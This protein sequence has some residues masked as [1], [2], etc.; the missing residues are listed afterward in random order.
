[1]ILAVLWLPLDHQMSAG[2]AHRQSLLTRLL[3]LLVDP[4]HRMIQEPS[5]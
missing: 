5:Q 1:M 2:Y 4:T 3:R